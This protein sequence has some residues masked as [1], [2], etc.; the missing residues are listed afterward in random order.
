[1]NDE[2]VVIDKYLVRKLQNDVLCWGSMKV[3]KV[4]FHKLL[5]SVVKLQGPRQA[6]VLMF[7]RFGSLILFN[8]LICVYN[9]YW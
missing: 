5:F 8:S 3:I 9:I 2:C 6:F 4:A 7:E 1:M